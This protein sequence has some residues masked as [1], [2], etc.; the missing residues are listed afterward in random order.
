MR[1]L[2]EP[3]SGSISERPREPGGEKARIAEWPWALLAGFVLI[4]GAGLGYYADYPIVRNSLIYA[5]IA[6]YMLEFGSDFS[7]AEH[8]YNK[9]LGFPALSLPMVA[10]FGANFGLKVS[11][12]IWTT[13]WLCSVV[14]FFDHLKRVFSW[15][16]AP[17]PN[18]HLYLALLVVNPLVFYQF[19]SAYPDTLNA[20]VF[21]WSLYF[22]ERMT[23]KTAWR[24]DGA[25]FFALVIL[26]IWIKHHG[27]VLF[28][29]LL[30]F[31]LCR[32]LNLRWQWDRD[33][34]TV[35]LSLGS[36]AGT[37]AIIVAAQN[38]YLPI[39]NLSQNSG[40]Y[41][42]G[43][44][45]LAPVIRTN[46]GVF[47]N[48]LWISFAILF[49]F[50]FRWKH[51]AKYREWYISLSIF[52]VTI[53]LYKGARHNIRYFLPIAPLLV[54]IICN[55]L[56]RLSR[57]IAIAL[58]AIFLAGNGFLSVYYNNPWL[59]SLVNDVH[60]LP[61]HDNLRLVNEL[62]FRDRDIR[63][64]SQASGPGRDV[65][66]FS[67][68]YYNGGGWY[69]WERAGLFPPELQIEY[70]TK[71]NW[72]FITR[73]AEEHELEQALYYGSLPKSVAQKW[74]RKVSMKKLSSRSYALDFK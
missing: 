59:N 38:G 54:W 9:A 17:P 16:D 8:G 33:R 63:A 51:V 7:V 58:V 66:F 72:K 21:L 52:I 35:W 6:D 71:P 4:G 57:K 15:D 1:E 13:L 22:L 55:N 46:L 3:S 10:I 32:T 27:F 67:L 50:A 24:W 42:S 29:L 60:M 47:A 65:L 11:S 23:S 62:D 40:N 28:A 73:Y 39:F 25:I 20:A 69:V 14:Y 64:I 41:G 34:S 45:N 18:A 53:L 70:M 37:L 49:P 61:V 2:R 56:N 48:Y 26:S 12:F 19:V 5:R 30:V 36:F 31:V 68:P 43:M 74:D 44:G